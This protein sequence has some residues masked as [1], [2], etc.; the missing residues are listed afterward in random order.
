MASDTFTDATS[1]ESQR[2]DDGS[3]KGASASDVGESLRLQQQTA[4]D[5]SPRSVHGFRVSLSHP[6][7]LPI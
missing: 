1:A 6:R 5:E 4:Y 3:E 7:L 2:F